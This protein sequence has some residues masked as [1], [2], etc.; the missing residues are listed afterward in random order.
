[1][2]SIIR[3]LNSTSDV[4]IIASNSNNFSIELIVEIG[5]NDLDHI[6]KISQTLVKK[7]GE[8]AQFTDK[9]IL[10]YFN[11]NTIAKYESAGVAKW[12]VAKGQL[13]TRKSRLPHRNTERVQQSIIDSQSP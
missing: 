11:Q 1:M 13:Q 3:N 9:S 6:K 7:L 2:A 12:S 5:R 4:N 10:K 8:Q